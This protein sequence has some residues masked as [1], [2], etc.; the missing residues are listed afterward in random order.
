[1]TMHPVLAPG[2]QLL[3]APGANQATCW[4]NRHARIARAQCYQGNDGGLQIGVCTSCP[5][6]CRRASS[7]K[8]NCRDFI[9]T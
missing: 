3:T 8:A 7:A 4:L 5:S 9:T 1:L 2:G 6:N